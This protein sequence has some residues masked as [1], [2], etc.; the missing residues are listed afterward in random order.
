MS[1]RVSGTC[2][3]MCS[4]IPDLDRIWLYIYLSLGWRTGREKARPGVSSALA[5]CGIQQNRYQHR[6]PLSSTMRVAPE[7]CEP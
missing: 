3:N 1:A 6:V 2:R 4:A 5:P 7:L